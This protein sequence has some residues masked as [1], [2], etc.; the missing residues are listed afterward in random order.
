MSLHL[1]FL[2]RLSI[3]LIF[4]EGGKPENPEKNPRGMRE[5]NIRNKLSSDMTSSNPGIEPGSQYVVKG[6][7]SH[8]SATHT[9]MSVLAN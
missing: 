7:R 8:R 6:R 4:D 9:T 2:T 1:L 3:L 5:N